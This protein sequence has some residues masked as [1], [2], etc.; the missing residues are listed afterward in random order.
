MYE[1]R[2]NKERVSRTIGGGVARQWMKIE[3]GKEGKTWQDQIVRKNPH[4]HICQFA[5]VANINCPSWGSSA[6]L[7]SAIHSRIQTRFLRYGGA[8]N[9]RVE[10][11]HS[12]PVPHQHDIGDMTGRI[13]RYGEIKPNVQNDINNGINQIRHH[14]L[15]E[16]IIV[17]NLGSLQFPLSK[18]DP[19]ASVQG[20]NN[21]TLRVQQ[22]QAGLLVYDGQ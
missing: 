1:A 14:R 19:R 8:N 18:I 4:S 2:Q 21:P 22:N 11:P 17:T 5:W 10:I 15:S 9:P 3:Y 7:G 13:Y 6:S 12:T 20:N 16:R